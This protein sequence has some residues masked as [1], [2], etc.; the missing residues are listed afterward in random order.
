MDLA[1]S[2]W[3]TSVMNFQGLFELDRDKYRLGEPFWVTLVIQN[4]GDQNGF[5][6]VPR[7]RADGLQIIVKQGHG[8]HVKDL[9]QE[10]EGGLVPEQKLPPNGTLR[11]RYQLSEWLIITEPGDYAVECA[12]EVE[13][14]ST[15]LHEDDANRVAT[16]VHVSNDLRFTI[17]P[18]GALG[19]DQSLLRFQDS[20]DVNDLLNFVQVN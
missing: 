20:G 18:T 13:V 1:N 10:S 8:I 12:I 4:L 14:Y 16:R 19:E 7:A 9:S 11:Q 17:L 15:S 2:K 5:L 6:F 3:M